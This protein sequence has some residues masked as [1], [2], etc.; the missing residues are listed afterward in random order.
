MYVPMLS[1][2]MM[3]L[4]T[5]IIFAA[6]PTQPSLCA[7]S[8]SNKSCTIARSAA[9]AGSAFWDRKNSSLQISRIMGN[10][11]LRISYVAIVAEKWV[12]L[13][14]IYGGFDEDT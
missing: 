11:P 12:R 8:V 3:R 10:P 13:N 5:P 14:C 1:N 9:V 6:M 7:A 4:L 2:A